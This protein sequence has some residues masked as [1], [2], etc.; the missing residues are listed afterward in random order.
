MRTGLLLRTGFVTL[1]VA[2]NA[3][4]QIDVERFKPA[5]TYDGWVT[6]EG[7]GTRPS[8]D[9]WEFGLLLNYGLNPLVTTDEDGELR[10]QIVGGRLGAD[11]IGSVS[12]ADPFAIGLDLPLYVLQRG[13]AD[14]SMAGLGDLRIVP[15]LRI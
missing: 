2:V 6:G 15:K 13:D 10:D 8:D 3:A 12:V 4:A 11:L 14:P 9:P 1:A 7:S 5:V